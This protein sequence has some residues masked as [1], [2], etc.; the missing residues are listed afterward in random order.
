MGL[1]EVTVS[2]GLW[3]NSLLRFPRVITVKGKVL[4]KAQVLHCGLFQGNRNSRIGSRHYQLQLVY[5][6]WHFNNNYFLWMKYMYEVTYKKIKHPYL[7]R[8]T[9]MAHICHHPWQTREFFE[10]RQARGR[11]MWRNLTKLVQT[12]Y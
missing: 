5:F 4:Y 8:G 2:R 1:L 3:A 6:V 12:K 11:P 9:C 7:Q 10:D